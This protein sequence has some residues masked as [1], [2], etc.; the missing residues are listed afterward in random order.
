MDRATLESLLAEGLSL[1]QIGRRVDRHPSTVGYWVKKH[2]LAPPYA[3]RH[4]ARGGIPHATLAGLVAQALSIRE[5]ADEVRPEHRD[6]PTLAARIRTC[7]R[8]SCAARSDR[9]AGASDGRF[10][11]DCRRHGRTRVRRPRRRRATVPSLP[12][13]SG[14]QATPAGQG[15]LWSRR[16]A[17]AALSA[18]T[19]ERR[20]APVPPPSTRR[21]S[22]RRL[23]SRASLARSS[24]SRGGSEVRSSLLELPCRSRGW[25]DAS[26][27]LTFA[28][29]LPIIRGSATIRGSSIG[30]ASGC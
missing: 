11:A 9:G 13:R 4:A 6:R 25:R 14:D 20:R 18:A 1:E 21:R 28:A 2:G 24:G 15:D 22:V 12:R 8:P 17:V 7:A 16:L 30:R 27:P 5:I 10:V 26:R 19:P 3:Q 23:P 29:A